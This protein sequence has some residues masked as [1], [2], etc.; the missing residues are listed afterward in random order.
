MT[1]V[2]TIK[3]YA[4][5]PRIR[6]PVPARDRAP[7]IPERAAHFCAPL[8]AAY[9]EG[10][11]FFP[12]VSFDFRAGADTLEIRSRKDDGEWFTCAWNGRHT[13]L[14]IRDVSTAWARECDE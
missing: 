12:P 2:A 13:T 9:A 5:L 10:V 8:R 4:V 11:L 6:P 3:T 7:R 1:D 14:Q